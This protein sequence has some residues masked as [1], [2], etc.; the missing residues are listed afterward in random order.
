MEELKY[1]PEIHVALWNKKIN[2]YLSRY[3]E[4]EFEYI[5]IS[6]DE[7]MKLP[8]III[9]PSDESHAIII[10]FHW[11]HLLD[12]FHPRYLEFYEKNQYPP[13]YNPIMSQISFGACDSTRKEFDKWDIDTDE[14]CPHHEQYVYEVV[15]F[16][17]TINEEDPVDE[18][19]YWRN[20][21]YWFEIPVEKKTPPQSC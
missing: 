14:Y 6:E 17:E 5:V 4:T 13:Q 8:R 15:R 16:Y 21:G 9:D 11:T 1:I 18:E 12:P 19:I 2:K 20:R 7:E 10:G 3:A